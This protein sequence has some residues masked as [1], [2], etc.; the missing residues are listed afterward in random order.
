MH[1][2]EI[3]YGSGKFG[4][5]FGSQPLYYKTFYQRSIFAFYKAALGIANLS[6]YDAK[7]N[8]LQV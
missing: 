7:R 1:H 3:L 5:L 6:K 8:T 2:L 4:I